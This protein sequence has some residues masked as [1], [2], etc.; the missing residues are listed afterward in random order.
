MRA[1]IYI[2]VNIRNDEGLEERGY[3]TH[4]ITLSNTEAVDK[5]VE[6]FQA[7]ALDDAGLKRSDLLEYDSIQD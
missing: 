3:R 4:V 6:H 5:L 1:T 7:G 2:E